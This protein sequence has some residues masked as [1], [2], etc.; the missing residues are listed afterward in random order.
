M[1][2]MENQK[3]VSLTPS[4]AIVDDATLTVAELDTLNFDWCMYVLWLGATDIAVTSGLLTHGDTSGSGHITMPGTTLGTAT[5][6]DGDESAVP[7]A[8]DDNGFFIW[9]ID[10]RNKKRY[11][12]AT[13]VIGDGTAGTFATVFALLGRGDKVP[14]TQAAMGAVQV[15]RVE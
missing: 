10:L 7:S 4:A 11:I 12:D 9:S 15:I 8:T 2:N 3:F 13:I 1:N 5:D 6:I 14:V